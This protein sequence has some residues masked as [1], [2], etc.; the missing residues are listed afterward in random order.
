VQ[1]NDYSDL[2]NAGS[3]IPRTTTTG[4]RRN[5]DGTFSPVT[6][7]ELKKPLPNSQYSINGYTYHTDGQGR[8][9]Q[10]EGTLDRLDSAPRN[11]GQQS[12]VG[13]AGVERPEGYKR[14]ESDDGGH[15]IGSRFHG[16]GESINMVPV[17]SALNQN[18]MW[19]IMEDGWERAI[20]EG[21]VVRVRIELRYTGS[22]ARP[23]SFDIVHQV[24]DGAATPETIRNTRTG[25]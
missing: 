15:L 16:A 6:P 21:N 11:K 2:H 3:A 23:D 25:R 9:T 20:K 22:S 10:V 18:G 7:A 8:V 24:G 17:N 12:A 19:K 1:W 4:A 14:G 13:K 5:A